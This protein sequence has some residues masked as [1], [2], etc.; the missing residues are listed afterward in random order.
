MR[1][2]IDTDPGMGSKGADPEDGLAILLA[3]WSPEVTVEAVTVVAGNVPTSHS[4]SNLHRLLALADRTD[5]PVRSGAVAPLNPDRVPQ[6]A[7]LRM[8]EGLVQDDVPLV[9]LPDDDGGAAELI[10]DT[11]LAAP[12]EITVVAIGP[13][14]NLARAIGL[15]PSVA[16]AMARLVIMGGTV[17][18][19]G[20]VTPAAEFNI[21]MDP[22]A[23]DVVFRSG[24]TITMVGLD[25]CH[26]T[27]FDLSHVAVLR[28]NGDLAEFVADAAASWI[29]ARGRL[30]GDDDLHLYDS[31]AMAAAIHPDL[32]DTTPA[33]VQVETGDG[34]AQG[35]TVAWTNDVLRRVLTGLEPN[36]D[37][38]VGVDLDRFDHLFRTRILTRLESVPPRVD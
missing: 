12:G 25:V 4:W 8:R 30:S 26:R 10:R 13:L 29:E 20:N 5:V 17:E 28:G 11:V 35:M 38:A 1:L 19:A 37:V 15:D 14:T 36:T 33:L 27:H 32:V 3:L 24:A 31:L 23:A 16:T 6:N 7:G 9:P 34:P 2:I 18:V 21:W 22:E